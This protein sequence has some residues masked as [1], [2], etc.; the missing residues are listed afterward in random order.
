V[1]ISS[2]EAQS[3]L[4]LSNLT[5]NA[6]ATIAADSKS[7][8]ELIFTIIQFF[9]NSAINFGNTTQI[10]SDNS[11]KVKVSHTTTVSHFFSTRFCFISSIF[12]SSFLLT[13]FD[14]IKAQSLSA[15]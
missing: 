1:K 4:S 6:S 2:T 12:F 8:F 7:I 14:L 10:F 13:L 11:F 3:E 15:Q 5:S 9:M